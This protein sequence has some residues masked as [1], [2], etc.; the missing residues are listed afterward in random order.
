MKFAPILLYRMHGTYVH[1]FLS[2]YLLD[3]IHILAGNTIRT[4]TLTCSGLL[5]YVKDIYTY[6]RRGN[7]LC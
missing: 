7:I 6:V 5:H 3:V 4:S 1:I 2:N